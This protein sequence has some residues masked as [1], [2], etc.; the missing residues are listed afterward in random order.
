VL[1]KDSALISQSELAAQQ[2]Q[3]MHTC[4]MLGDIA[5]MVAKAE[6]GR[7]TRVVGDALKETVVEQQRLVNSLK[8]QI[9]AQQHYSS[10]VA[11]RCKQLET[12]L[13]TAKRRLKNE[14][15]KSYDLEVQNKELR[16]KVLDAQMNGTQKR[17][18]GGDVHGNYPSFDLSSGEFI[19]EAPLASGPGDEPAM[20]RQPT[21]AQPAASEVRCNVAAHYCC[22]ECLTLTLSQVLTKRLQGTEVTEQRD[23]VAALCAAASWTWD[24]TELQSLICSSVGAHAFRLLVR[25]YLTGGLVSSADDRVNG[26][27]G[28][29][30]S[31]F[32]IGPADSTSSLA[33]HTADVGQSIM[34]SDLGYARPPIA[35][36]RKKE[37]HA[38]TIHC[39]VYDHVLFSFV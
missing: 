31:L 29:I 17:E 23:R 36:S 8:E 19:G 22:D 38:N 1:G 26:A 9:A 35:H 4:E 27:I 7:S 15:K 25:N 2:S 28:S 18:R 10:K 21:S 3:V 16:I 20:T 37:E 32:R 34:I 14:M 30:G 12:E 13:E 39:S 33:A 6:R 11:A 24:F 5:N